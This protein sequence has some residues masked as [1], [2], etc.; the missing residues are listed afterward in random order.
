MLPSSHIHQRYFEKEL[1]RERH[2][3]LCSKA[4]EVVILQ[5]DFR[6]GLF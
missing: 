2:E 4:K 5:S 3:T 1:L 6:K